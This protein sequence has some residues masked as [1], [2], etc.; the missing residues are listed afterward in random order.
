M[1]HFPYVSSHD[2][3]ESSTRISYFLISK[4]IINF[5]DRIFFSIFDHVINFVPW[6]FEKFVVSFTFCF[7]VK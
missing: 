1:Y 2:L 6:P 7:K 3:P 5:I 4:N